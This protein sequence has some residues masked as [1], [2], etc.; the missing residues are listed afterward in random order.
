M[1]TGYRLALVEDDEYMGSSLV[2]RLELEGA[3]VIWLR[4]IT[5]A[6]GAIRTPRQPIDAVIC[7]IRLPDGTGEELFN[8]LCQSVSPP[9]FLFITGHGGIEQA[10]RLIQAGAADYVTKP[11]EMAVFL[12]RLEMLLSPR[13]TQEMPPILGVSPAARRIDALA[14][15]AAQS[16][17]PVMIH[18][19]PGTGKGLIARRIHECSDRRAAPFVTVNLA[20]EPGAGDA[21]FGT[22]GAWDK[23]GEGILFLQS[24]N[25]LPVDLLPRVLNMLDN[26]FEGRLIASCGLEMSDL[27]AQDQPHAEFYYR[28]NPSEIQVPPLAERPEDAVWLMHQL[29]EGLNS[30]RPTPLTGISR[31]CDEAVRSHHWPGGGREVRARLQRAVE[32][33]ASKFLQPVDLF[34]DRSERGQPIRTLTE[35]REAAEKTQII[36]TLAHTGGQIGRAAELLRISRTT[37]WEKMQKLGIIHRPGS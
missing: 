25:R 1:L 16:D 34:P 13:S 24:V 9:P 12:E 6:L 19:G 22:G 36:N 11:F 7:D 31:L 5:R 17:R 2:Q 30:R 33:A 37:L 21:L 28:L 18:G 20:R 8:R 35:A 14:V 29:F 4:Q 23:T 32:N 3:E 15:S 27:I 10:V 26:G